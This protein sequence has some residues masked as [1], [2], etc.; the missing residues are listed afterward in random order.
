MICEYSSSRRCLIGTYMYKGMVPLL[1]LTF[2]SEVLRH[3]D[4]IYPFHER[5]DRQDT[6]E[7]TLAFRSLRRGKIDDVRKNG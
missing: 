3:T 6:L 7:V 4:N 5:S 1:S 2:E